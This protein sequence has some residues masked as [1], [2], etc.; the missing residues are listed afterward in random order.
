MVARNDPELLHATA[1]MLVT[2]KQ[3]SQEPPRG[4]SQLSEPLEG[5]NNPENAE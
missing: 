2:F 1:D 3:A 5:H 4:P